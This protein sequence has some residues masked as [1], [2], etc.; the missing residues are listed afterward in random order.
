MKR[1]S[2]STSPEEQRMLDEINERER[3][4]Q[5]RRF[6]E[7]KERFPNHS[8]AEFLSHTIQDKDGIPEDQQSLVFMN[9]DQEESKKVAS[10]TPTISRGR[11]RPGM[12][13]CKDMMGDCSGKSGKMMGCVWKTEDDRKA[14]YVKKTKKEVTKKTRA[15]FDPRCEQI[16]TRASH[17]AT[18][19][20]PG[21]KGK[22]GRIAKHTKSGVSQSVRDEYLV[23][24]PM[25]QKKKVRKKKSTSNKE[26][27]T[28]EIL[29]G[30]RNEESKTSSSKKP[31]KPRK[32]RKKKVL[33]HDCHVWSE[34]EI[35][36]L[37]A[38]KN[39]VPVQKRVCE[40]GG[41]VWTHGKNNPSSCGDCWCCEPALG[42]PAAD[43]MGGGWSY[44]VNPETG[45]KV[46]IYG[47]IGQ[48]VLMN[49][50]NML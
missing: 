49:Y 16:K 32:P 36:A 50:V 40:E 46:N 1:S 9:R 10:E 38:G 23:A 3:S 42:M 24:H 2:S 14:E 47:K 18:K 21:Q 45:R 8:Y 20:I 31:K 44:I 39:K 48:R 19:Y 7:H 13:L 34:S 29:F 4:R 6:E 28:P 30:E 43:L 26:P 35:T 5:I 41:N 22:T 11:R 15:N 12:K 37:K 25:V 33:A 27:S 17:K